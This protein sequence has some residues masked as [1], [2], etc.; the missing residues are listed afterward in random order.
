MQHIDSPKPHRSRRVARLAALPLCLLSLSTMTS[1]VTSVEWDFHDHQAIDYDDSM[2][3]VRLAEVTT[4]DGRT[5]KY[6][7]T[8]Q[9]RR[10]PRGNDDLEGAILVSTTGIAE[11][12]YLGVN[13]ASVDADSAEELGL[14]PWKGVLISKVEPESAAKDAGLKRGDLLLEVNGVALASEE[15]FAD[16]VAGSL[17]PNDE[18]ELSVS[19]SVSDFVREDIL[20]P[21]VV[22]MR[23]IEETDSDRYDYPLDPVLIGQ[24]GLGVITLPAELGSVIYGRSET[25]AVISAVVTGSPAYMAGI[26]AGDRILRANGS[27]VL[28]AYDV[29]ELL[30]QGAEELDLFLGGELG[31]HQAAFEVEA[32]VLKETDVH[33]PIIVDYDARA[34]RSDL[35]VLEFIFQFG[36]EKTN[37]YLVSRTRKPRQTSSLSILP[38]G[39]FEFTRT[40][41]R[42]TNRIFWLIKWSTK[43]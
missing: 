9:S 39:M 10:F 1:C 14:T 5:A 29:R 43:R 42:S 2:G 21:V 22:G 6:S 12:P 35:N 33:V 38:L 20:V 4:E 41:T 24:A 27:P 19:R 37:N 23:T 18:I 13:V 15:Q 30:D 31:A 3:P 8:G 11:L 26:R 28:T 17:R 34:D 32:D 36:F 40:P 16:L 7:I 25:A